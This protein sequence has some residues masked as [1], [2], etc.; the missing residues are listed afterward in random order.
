VD[1]KAGDVERTIG[2][3]I[4]NPKI[5]IRNK[6]KI[7]NGKSRN[8]LTPALSPTWASGVDGRIGA[9]EKGDSVA[10]ANP[11]VA[12]AVRTRV[13]GGFTARLGTRHPM[14]TVVEL[15]VGVMSSPLRRYGKFC[16]VGGSGVVVDMA[17]LGLL[18]TGLG[19]NLSLAKVVAAETAIINNYTWNNLWTFRGR[20]GVGWR[21][22]L[23][24]LGRF[25]LICLAGIGWS[26]LLLNAGV[27]GLGLNVYLAN[28]I[29][30]VLVSLW[31]FWLSERFGWKPSRGIGP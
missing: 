29:A 10:G 22:W 6:F 16:L 12:S 1:A 11:G 31:N 2:K 3:F 21:G 9:R 30:I 18:A 20:S 4:R 17:V 26:V 19:W 25:N 23:A 5:E 7:K 24:G 8:L 13:A 27:H 15:G 28:G 14:R